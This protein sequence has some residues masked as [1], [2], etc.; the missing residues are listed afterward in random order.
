MQRCSFEPLCPLFLQ[1]LSPICLRNPCGPAI[2]IRIAGTY[3]PLAY[4]MRYFPSLYISATLA[5]Q[6]CFRIHRPIKCMRLSIHPK[7]HPSKGSKITSYRRKLGSWWINCHVL[8]WVPIFEFCRFSNGTQLSSLHDSCIGEFY[9]GC[10]FIIDWF[11]ATYDP[12]AC[13]A[14]LFSSAQNNWTYFISEFK[15]IKLRWRL[16]KLSILDLGGNVSRNRYYGV[17]MIEKICSSL[18]KA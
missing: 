15:F 4:M 10:V 5:D 1:L 16:I 9:N 14:T 11:W 8:I 7:A 2:Y 12:G 17:F 13:F 3:L 18:L 6:K